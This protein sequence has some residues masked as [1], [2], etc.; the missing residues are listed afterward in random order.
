MQEELMAK[1]SE[2]EELTKNIQNMA[3]IE[4]V[5]SGLLGAPTQCREVN[6]CG[7]SPFDNFPKVI[8][9]DRIS[10]HELGVPN[11]IVCEPVCKE[12]R[13]PCADMKQQGKVYPTPEQMKKGFGPDC[14]AERYIQKDLSRELHSTEVI[15]MLDRQGMIGQPYQ[16]TMGLNAHMMQPQTQAYP[17]IFRPQMAVQP[18]MM[19]QQGRAG[20]FN[21]PWVIP[22]QQ[23]WPVAPQTGG[24]MGP[25][26]GMMG[27]QSGMMGPQSG[28][29]GPQP[30]MAAPMGMLSAQGQM[31]MMPPKPLP[32]TVNP[33]GQLN[34]M[35]PQGQFNTMNPQGQL[36]TMNPQGQLNVMN[37]Q[38]PPGMYQTTDPQIT[39]GMMQKNDTQPPTNMNKTDTQTP[40]ETNKIKDNTETPSS[41][42]P[43]GKS[44]LMIKHQELTST[45]TTTKISSGNH[46]ITEHSEVDKTQERSIEITTV[47][48]HKPDTERYFTFNLLYIIYNQYLSMFYKFLF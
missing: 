27:P 21:H 46:L 44:G 17:V 6:P 30:G 40:Q 2:F 1:L 41:S 36:N 35:N 8:C 37:P 12:K 13:N 20:G 28:M 38:A 48:K 5:S 11:M 10:Q 9:F 32:A 33:Q 47:D 45:Q 3:G 31:T 18:G 39:H 43:T 15:G 23:A 16:N 25:Q 19:I 14:D 24:M 4:N 22:G 34:T 42:D 26:P 29:M 7:P